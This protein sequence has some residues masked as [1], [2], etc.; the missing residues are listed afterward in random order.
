[1]I[2]TETLITRATFQTWC[3]RSVEYPFLNQSSKDSL[4]ST[5]LATGRGEGSGNV[6]SWTEIR[7]STRTTV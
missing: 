7:N 6:R 3:L 4:L 2:H 1:M 5:W